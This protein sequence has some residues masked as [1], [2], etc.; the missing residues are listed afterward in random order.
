MFWG[1]LSNE[2]KKCGLEFDS[3]RGT[4]FPWPV[5]LDLVVPLSLWLTIFT[6]KVLDAGCIIDLGSWTSP[7]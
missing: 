1:F 3:E 7:L 4:L 6:I 5:T 2:V